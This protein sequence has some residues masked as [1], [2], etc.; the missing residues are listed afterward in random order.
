MDFRSVHNVCFDCPDQ[1]I[2]TLRTTPSI[3]HFDRGGILDDLAQS[4]FHHLVLPIRRLAFP[5]YVTP[6]I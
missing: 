5:V 6:T 1:L 4:Y 2:M 3:G